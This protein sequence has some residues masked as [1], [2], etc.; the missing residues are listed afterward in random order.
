MDTNMNIETKNFNIY[1][2][3]KDGKYTHVL[4]FLHGKG[5][6]AKSYLYFFLGQKVLP[7]DIPIKIILL[8]SPYK[9]VMLERPMGTS[10]FTISS[11]PLVSRECYNFEEAK[12]V[13][14]DIEKVIDEE[15]K[16]IECKYENIFIGG[17]SQGGCLALLVGLTFE[18]ILGGVICLSGYLFPEIEIKEEKKNLNIFVGHGEED[19]VIHFLTS[20]EEMKR[21][22]N[23]KGFEK[24][25]YPGKGHT[26]TSEEIDDLRNFLIICMKGKNN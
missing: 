13:K 23:F 25:S 19:D 18:H 8:Q 12:N 22:E 15:V 20:M 2:T 9:K 24:H 14:K 11:F 26:I 6:I 10:W 5:D 4:I 3:P 21:I 7:S 17:F 16:L 1:I